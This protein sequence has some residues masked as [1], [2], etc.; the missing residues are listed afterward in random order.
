[1]TTRVSL[2]R[3]EGAD[4]VRD[5]LESCQRRSAVGERLHED[6]DPADAQQRTALAEREGADGMGRVVL[7]QV[8]GDLP[9]EAHEDDHGHRGDEEVGGERE[10]PPR[11][12]QP[13]EV[14]NEQEQD[15]ADG[16]LELVG[17]EGR[18]R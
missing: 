17:G 15:D 2:R 11:L 1:M 3:P 16:D 6:V 12:T 10:Q 8:S 13:A 4:A 9:V 5:R 14:A 7:G 18:H